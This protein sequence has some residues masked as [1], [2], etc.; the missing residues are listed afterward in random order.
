MSSSLASSWGLLVMAPKRPQVVPSRALT[1]RS[2]RA[3]PSL[4]Q[5]SQPMSQGMY[6]ASNFIASRTRREA[7]MTS[8]PIPSP[9]I[10]AIEYFGICS[11]LGQENSRDDRMP[12]LVGRHRGLTLWL[13]KSGYEG[14]ARKRAQPA[15]RSGGGVWPLRLAGALRRWGGRWSFRL[16]AGRGVGALE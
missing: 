9:G 12:V 3:L 16:D 11:P 15:R 6:W 7:S 2:G 8:L 1:V 14:L 10:Q 13:S 4:H 5:N